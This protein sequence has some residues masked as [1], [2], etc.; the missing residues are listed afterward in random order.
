MSAPTAPL[1]DPPRPV[2]LPPDA[3][4]RA[5]R[6]RSVLLS[7]AA[8]SCIFLSVP[9]WG[10]WPLAFVGV[11][12][13]DRL[14]A[15]QPW[16][17]RFARTWLVAAAWLFPGMLWMWDLTPPGYVIA[18]TVY[19]GYFALAVALAPAGRGRWLGLPAAVVLAELCR[20]SFPFGGVPLAHLAM[21]QADAPLRFVVRI[22]GSL[23]LVA[24][25]VVGGM[26]LAAAS[27]R[28]WRPAAI[29]AAVV[30]ATGLIGWMAPSGQAVDTLD[31]AIVQ[32]GGPQRTR[33]ADTDEEVVFRRHLAASELVETPVD[34]VLW[35]ENVVNV[36]GPITDHE[37]YPELQQLARD[38]DATLS[39][40]VVEGLDDESFANAQI[41][42]GP[43]GEYVDR[44]DKVRTVPFG[45]FVPARDVL[46][47]VAGESGLPARDAVA[48]SGPGVV[49]TEFGPMGV[50]ISWEVFFQNRGRE[51][52]GTGDGHLLLNP[53]NGASYW[54]TL[55]QSQ[56]VASS[57]LRALE[58]GRW[59]AQAAPTGFSAV[60]TPEGE[61]VERTAVSEQAV[62][63][64]TVEL[65]EG[66]T[67]ATV[68]GYW[69]ALVL[70]LLAYPLG[71]W[72]ERRSALPDPSSVEVS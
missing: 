58:T 66:N 34:F 10:W 17:T 44:Y 33:A 23:L 1:D 54:L 12:I 55:V 47:R 31:I 3:P 50:L 25:V 53:T 21:S 57:Q 38:L 43:D 70:S 60:V 13:W 71:W 20:W 26:A 28:Q 40:G 46:E 69:P 24:V 6:W 11:A 37:W 63:M 36:E 65:R 42:L 18:A 14:V 19:A 5:S 51:A 48:G 52:I 9:P 62:I 30:V 8:G 7:L 72:I 4:A 56:Q 22:A 39:F 45:E 61:L 41:V 68:V 27:R 29:G 49:D 32:G 67:W 64:A 16:R 15:E 35:P 2:G 59:V